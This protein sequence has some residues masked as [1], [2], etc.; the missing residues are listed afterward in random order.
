MPQSVL[1]QTWQELAL[2][3]QPLLIYHSEDSNNVR[4]VFLVVPTGINWYAEVGG[5]T[6]LDLED[7]GF[8]PGHDDV[9]HQDARN[10]WPMRQLPF[11]FEGGTYFG[12][13]P[14]SST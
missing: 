12:M 13:M 6:K 8:F 14:E 9:H 3:G 7:L 4:K 11:L 1:Q 10:G 2:L 5:I